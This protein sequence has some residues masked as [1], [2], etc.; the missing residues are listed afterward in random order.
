MKKNP[1]ISVTIATVNAP[2]SLFE[3]LKGYFNQTLKPLEIIVVC[4]SQRSTKIANFLKVNKKVNLVKLIKFDGDKNEARNVGFSKSSGNFVIYSDDDMIPQENLIE[5]CTKRTKK[6]DALIIPEHG[7]ATGKYLAKVYSLEK[8]LVNSDPDALTPRLFKRSLFKN[9]EM[10][11]DKK[12]GILDEWG[13]NLKLKAKK[14]KIGT[15]NL[16]SFTV[17]DESTLGVRIKKSFKKGLWIRSLIKENKKEGLRRVNPI[18]RG[19]Q[20]YGGKSHYFKKTPVIFTSLLFIK[21]LDV[22]AFLLGLFVS[23]ITKPYA[24]L[25]KFK[26]AK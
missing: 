21:S 22:F 3:S 24:H 25:D 8:E 23:L 13:F 7:T 16:S 10:P 19:I 11:F 4:S 9:S 14:T 26:F 1:T 15:I 6:F 12:F 2:Y 20:F 18:K 5:E 17:I